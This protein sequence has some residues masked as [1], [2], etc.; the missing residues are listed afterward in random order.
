MKKKY[1]LI[2][3]V[4]IIIGLVVIAYAHN[5]QIKDHYIE[6]QEKR[7]DL[8]FKYNL[9]NY[10]SMKITS[11]K[12]TPMGGYIVDGYVNH[13]KNY[14]FKVLIS[15]TDNHQFE[16]SIGYD[17]K[18]FGKLFKEKDHKNELKSTDIIKKEHLDKS[19]YEADPPLFFFSGRLE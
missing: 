11:F 5:K 4:V 9:N 18:T 10:H 12:K 2:I 19:E 7:I 3:V 13:N 8:Y 1:I 16:D 17:D 15:A 6:I 14:D